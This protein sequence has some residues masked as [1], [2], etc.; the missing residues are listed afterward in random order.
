MFQVSLLKGW[1]T[2]N[3][4]ED[5]TATTN[6]NTDIEEPYYEIEKILHRRKV[7]RNKKISKNILFYGGDTQWKRLPESEQSNSAT[8]NN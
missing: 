2:A 1:S 5:L 4:Q 7:K 3:L 8:Q 6:D